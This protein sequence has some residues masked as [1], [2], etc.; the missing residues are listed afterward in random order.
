MASMLPIYGPLSKTISPRECVRLQSF[1]EYTIL[2][3][4]D[5]NAYKQFGNAVNVTMIRRAAR[6]LIFEEPLVDI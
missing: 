2:D 1:R 4:I 6:F 3:K 5:K